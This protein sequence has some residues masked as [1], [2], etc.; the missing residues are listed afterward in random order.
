[1]ENSTELSHNKLNA[2]RINIDGVIGEEDWG[3]LAKKF[4]KVLSTQEQNW[5]N[6]SG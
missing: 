2:W 6:I 4:T 5:N 3:E 1:M